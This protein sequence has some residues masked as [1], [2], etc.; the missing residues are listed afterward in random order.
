MTSTHVVSIFQNPTLK[1][2]YTV[3]STNSLI[4]DVNCNLVPSKELT[5]LF[6]E[7][8]FLRLQQNTEFLTTD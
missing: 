5:T 4:L 1:A 3:Y 8:L 6:S 7:L 2:V